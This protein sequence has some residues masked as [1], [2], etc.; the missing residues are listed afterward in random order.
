VL[1][2]L[3]RV[4]YN[5]AR[6][7]EREETKMKSYYIVKMNGNYMNSF[8]KYS[9]ACELRDQLQRRWRNATIEIETAYE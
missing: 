9:D 5:K 8:K 4:C 7:R 3:G 6:K 2:K 1:D